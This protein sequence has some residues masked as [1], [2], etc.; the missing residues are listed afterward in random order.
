M[1]CEIYLVHQ[2]EIMV[3][4]RGEKVDTIVTKKKCFY[5][6]ESPFRPTNQI[7]HVNFVE[8]FVSGENFPVSFLAFSRE[9]A[10]H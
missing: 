4:I 10:T 1:V 2:A 6:A 9:S 7:W 8:L 5:R 3:C